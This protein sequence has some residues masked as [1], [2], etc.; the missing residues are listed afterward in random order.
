M[1]RYKIEFLDTTFPAIELEEHANLPEELTE[2][3][4]PLQFGCCTGLCATCL[5]ELE[6]VDGQINPPN[7]DEI[8]L[9]ELMAPGNPKARLTCQLKLNGN[10]KLKKIEAKGSL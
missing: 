7:E 6:L 10:I 5:V 4:S 3:N 2:L 8:E 9:L 1:K